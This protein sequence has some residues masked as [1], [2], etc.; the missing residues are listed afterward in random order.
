RVIRERL[1]PRPHALAQHLDSDGHHGPQDQ[2]LGA[3]DHRGIVGAPERAAN[4]LVDD[5]ERRP[6]RHH[7]ATGNCHGGD[8]PDDAATD[9][10]IP[11]IPTLH[12]VPPSRVPTPTT[13]YGI[14]M[15][16]TTTRGTHAA[17]T[18]YRAAC[19]ARPALASCH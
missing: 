4:R 12:R 1:A 19:A 9:A 15:H 5:V 13:A 14:E 3:R 11:A 8:L 7:A 16:Y 2:P 10:G 17:P 6:P 18:T